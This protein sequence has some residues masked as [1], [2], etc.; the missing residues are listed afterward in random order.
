MP[1]YLKRLEIAELLKKQLDAAY[2]E[3]LMANA[4]LDA[5]VKESPS[6][7]PHPDGSLRLQ[8]AGVAARAAFQIY[9]SALREFTEFSVTW[10]PP[11]GISGDQT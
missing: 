4:R 7:L 8:Q 1:E 6:G 10:K 3:Y 11:Q 2:A 5:V 9:L